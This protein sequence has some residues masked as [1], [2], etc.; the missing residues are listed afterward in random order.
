MCQ[1]FCILADVGKQIAALLQNSLMPSDA[2]FSCTVC[3]TA[4]MLRTIKTDSPGAGFLR[5]QARTY[6]SQ[7]P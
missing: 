5:R 3:C 6:G 7:G 1:R 2:R 4:L